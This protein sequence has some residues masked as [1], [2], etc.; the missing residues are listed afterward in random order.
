MISL[1]NEK[2]ERFMEVCQNKIFPSFFYLLKKS[3]QRKIKSKGGI[4]KAQKLTF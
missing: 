2:D 4:G 3:Q 1:E